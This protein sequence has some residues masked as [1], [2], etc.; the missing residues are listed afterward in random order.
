[1]YQGLPVQVAVTSLIRCSQLFQSRKVHP[2][3]LAAIVFFAAHV[4]GGL[5][6][7]T[8]KRT[9]GVS[10]NLAAKVI[11]QLDTTHPSGLA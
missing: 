1:V 6:L 4:D 3:V 9:I 8:H 2:C 5:Q 11:A 10:E 7:G